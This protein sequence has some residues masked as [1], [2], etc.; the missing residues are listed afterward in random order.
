MELINKLN[1]Y[2]GDNIWQ[3]IILD[4][5]DLDHAATEALDPSGASDRF[6][7]VDGTVVAFDAATRQ[8]HVEEAPTPPYLHP[9]NPVHLH[10]SPDG[11][12]TVSDDT[13]PIFRG[14]DPDA[15]GAGPE[16]LA[17]I[18]L[19]AFDAGP[20]PVGTP[21]LDIREAGGGWAADGMTSR[22]PIARVWAVVGA[23]DTDPAFVVPWHAS[24]TGVVSVSV[25]GVDTPPAKVS[26]GRAGQAQPF[27]DLTPSLGELGLSQAGPWQRW[28]DVW[29]VPLDTCG[30]LDLTVHHPRRPRR[31]VSGSP[32]QIAEQIRYDWE[33]KGTRP[34]SSLVG[35]AEAIAGLPS[36]GERV[37]LDFRGTVR[38]VT[39][40][41]KAPVWVQIEDSS[42]P[43]EFVPPALVA[44][45][46]AGRPAEGRPVQ[47]R[48]PE[49]LLA[50]VDAAAA[51]AGVS[52]A[53]QI[54]RMLAAAL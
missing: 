27:W 1:G 15:R 43:A 50:A 5:V 24:R 19:R 38:E 34:L 14:T 8:W 48:L 35:L 13:G 26:S 6:A 42:F 51:Q 3:D 52:R 46:P 9:R 29:F 32:M 18:A 37:P 44:M 36:S 11:V 33:K 17:G 7:L 54:R 28:R 47:V 21:P 49:S 22:R 31:E 4:L 30:W 41:R 40:R 2:A 39:I 10:L 23:T 25:A 16:F 12:L 53:E 45:R 20:G